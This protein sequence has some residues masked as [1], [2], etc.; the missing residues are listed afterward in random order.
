MARRSAWAAALAL[1]LAAGAVGIAKGTSTNFSPYVDA[2]GG[3]ALPDPAQVRAAWHLLGTW[4]VQDD[5]GVAEFH[6]V[7]TQPG[8]IAAY[9]AT[10]EFAD[11]AVLVKEVRA[12]TRGPLT[13]GDVAWNGD[14]V[15]WFV[16]VKDRE[17]RFPDNPL[18]AESWGWALFQAED[19]ATNVA[20]AFE[21]DC[22]ACHEPARHTEW[23][24]KQGYPVL[25]D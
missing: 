10:G 22:M 12:A 1:S 25:H 23:V 14:E 17:N 20:T 3:I 21:A 5:D 2:A 13:T 8:S 16:M 24:F 19:R 4:A 11:A 7:Y 6:T 15:L 18:W 9:R